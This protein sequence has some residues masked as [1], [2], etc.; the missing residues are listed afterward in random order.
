MVEATP[1]LQQA[2]TPAQAQAMSAAVMALARQRAIKAVKQEIRDRGNKPQY[3]A[4]G[5]IVAAANDYLGNHRELIAEAKE[6]VLRWH[7]AGM[8]GPRGGIRTRAR[9]ARLNTHAQEAKA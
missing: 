8:F 2:P 1:I 9:R 4:R 7:A 6:T 3:M 5:E